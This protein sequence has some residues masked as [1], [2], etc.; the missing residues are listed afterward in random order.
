ML[1]VPRIDPRASK[2]IAGTAWAAA[3]IQAANRMSSPIIP[4]GP[5]MTPDERRKLF[6]RPSPGPKGY[7]APPGTGPE[8][9]TCGSCAHHATVRHASIYHKCGLLRQAWTR[10]QAT[11]IRVRSPACKLWERP[12]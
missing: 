11:D 2:W 9:E 6:G 8:G 3:D 4:D 7:A 12:A 5:A 10:G 1:W